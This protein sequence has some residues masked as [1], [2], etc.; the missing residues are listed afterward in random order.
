MT[1]QTHQ[2]VRLERGKHA[3]P[4][5]G[6]CVMELASMLAGEPFSDHP[7]AVSPV[8]ADFLRTYNDGLD[9][10][11]RQDLYRFASEAV[12]TRSTDAVERLRAEIAVRWADERR[13]ELRRG[14]GRLLPQPA[15]AT[16]TASDAGASAARTACKLVSKHRPGAHE[17]VLALVERLIG[18]CGPASALRAEGDERQHLDEAASAEVGSV[19]AEPGQA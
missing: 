7:Q 11:R 13:P 4:D 17:D 18:V 10:H 15:F 9:D 3:S 2:T 14:L 5:S 19:V 1:G 6:A 12:G 16:L 8:I